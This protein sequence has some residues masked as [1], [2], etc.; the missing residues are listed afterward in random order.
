MSAVASGIT[1]SD[2]MPSLVAILVKREDRQPVHSFKVRGAYAMIAGL[3]EEQKARGVVTASA[4]N[5]APRTLKLC[6]G[7]RS[8]RFTRMVLPRRDEIFS[9]TC[10]GVTCA[11]R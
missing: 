4:G 8:S 6:T 7:W 2:L 10:S 11:H 3:N 5:H 9:I 1:I